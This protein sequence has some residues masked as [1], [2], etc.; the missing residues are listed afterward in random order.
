MRSVIG[1]IVNFFELHSV[2][3]YKKNNNINN[4]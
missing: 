2:D 3:C 1:L 4:V